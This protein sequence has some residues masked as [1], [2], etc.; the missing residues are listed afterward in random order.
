MAIRDLRKRH[1]EEPLAGNGRQTG[2]IPVRGGRGAGDKN[3][4]VA[5]ECDEQDRGRRSAEKFRKAHFSEERRPRS[6]DDR[7]SRYSSS[8][9][10]V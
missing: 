10:P 8:K 4:S 6:Q 3:V 5:G 1:R 9:A 2:A 7:T